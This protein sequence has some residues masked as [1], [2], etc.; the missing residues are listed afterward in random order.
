MVHPTAVTMCPGTA[1]NRKIKTNM[2]LFSRMSWVKLQYNRFFFSNLN[3]SKL[4]ID[5][6]IVIAHFFALTVQSHL[7][8]IQVAISP[9]NVPAIKIPLPSPKPHTRPHKIPM[10]GQE[11]SLIDSKPGPRLTLMPYQRRER[12]DDQQSYWD[13][14]SCRPRSDM[15]SEGFCEPDHAVV[16]GSEESREGDDNDG[17]GVPL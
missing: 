9:R 3:K 8:A 10:T 11:F 7:N 6:K 4:V 15:P 16:L 14:P 13:Q 12:H 17:E 5:T 2:K 1:L